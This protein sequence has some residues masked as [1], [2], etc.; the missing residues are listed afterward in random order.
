MERPKPTPLVLEGGFS[1]GPDPVSHCFNTYGVDALA[2]MHFQRSSFQRIILLEVVNK[3][4]ISLHDSSKR[5]MKHNLSNLPK[6]T[7][8]QN[9]GLMPR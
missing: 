7:I 6:F 5:K 8:K 3:H 4:L 2:K 9:W 1:L